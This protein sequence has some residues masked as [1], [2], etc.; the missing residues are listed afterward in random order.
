MRTSSTAAIALLPI[1]AAVPAF[2]GHDDDLSRAEIAQ[3]AQVLAD[4]GCHGGEFDKKRD[5]YKVDDTRCPDGRKYDFRF[6][7][8][9]IIRKGERD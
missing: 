9:F 2:A 6:T 3:L 8:D 7:R 1:L 5:G 4:I